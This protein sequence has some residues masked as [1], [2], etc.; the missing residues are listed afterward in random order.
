[1]VALMVALIIAAFTVA[2]VINMAL[3]HILLFLA[4]LVGVL[5]ISTD[6]LSDRPAKHKMV[7]CLVVG[8][9]LFGMDRTMVYLRHVQEQQGSG[10][11]SPASG[12]EAQPVTAQRQQ[13]EKPTPSPVPPKQ[14]GET[15]GN[16]KRP[17]P[18]Q[19]QPNAPI[20][21]KQQPPTIVQTA[22]TFGN[23]GDRAIALSDDIMQD[24]YRYGWKNW[25]NRSGQQGPSVPKMPSSPEETQR[26]TS[27]RSHYF[28]FRFFEK[29]LDIR[30]EFAQLHLRDERLDDFFKYQGMIEQANRQMAAANP[31]HEIDVPILPQQIEEVAERLKILANQ[32]PIE[33]AAPRA[34]HFS[35]ARVQPEKPEFSFEII[36]TIDTDIDVSS[37]YIAV[38][39][40]GVRASTGTD[41]VDSKLVF[42]DENVVGNKP[43]KE[44]LLSH[45]RDSYILAIGKTPLTPKRPIHVVAYGTKPFSVT[46]VTLFD[47]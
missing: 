21:E 17:A 23:L 19:T 24:L 1:M 4:W 2:G 42:N 28:R 32:I 31:G 16:L 6:I 3:A 14:S 40:E 15:S 18:P 39:F 43:L 25:G 33:R 36:I 5:G 7:W 29:V 47:K 37:G 30:N 11:S 13:Q 10:N 27:S 12:P 45:S 9:A 41:F 35:V 38:E 34:L 8:I 26:W 46:K 44:Y 20:I 22:P